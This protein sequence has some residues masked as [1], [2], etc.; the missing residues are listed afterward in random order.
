[1]NASERSAGGNATATTTTPNLESQ[2]GPARTTPSPILK[3]AAKKKSTVA[4]A[5]AKDLPPPRAEK[6]RNLAEGVMS[7]SNRFDWDYMHDGDEVNDGKVHAQK[8]FNL[9]EQHLKDGTEPTTEEMVEVEEAETDEFDMAALLSA[10]SSE[11]NHHLL[12]A[13]DLGQI[14]HLP[15]MEDIGPNHTLRSFQGDMVPADDEQL[16]L[17]QKIAER[18]QTR[19]ESA[20]GVHRYVA[21][22][23]WPGGRVNY[24]FASDTPA[25]VRHMFVAATRQYKRAIPCLSFSNVG[26]LSGSSTDRISRQACK[27]TPAVFVQSHPRKGCYSYV[28]MVR[29][30]KAA[31]LQLQDP[32]CLSVGTAVHELGHALGMA[33]EQSRPDRDTYI[34]ID[35]RNVKKGRERNFGI[36]PSAGTHLKYDYLSVMHYDAYAFAI[37]RSKPTLYALNQLGGHDA[38]QEIGQ[39]MGLST[40]DVDQ[41][42]LAY[43]GE[44]AAGC[45]SNAFTGLG[46]INRPGKSGEDV[47]SS[48]SRCRRDLMKACCACGG[49]YKVQCYEGHPCPKP[50][51]LPPESDHACIVNKANLF[52]E[53]GYS[54][55]IFNRCFYPVEW[56]CPAMSCKHQTPPGVYRVQ[57]CNGK[58]ETDICRLGKC[59]VKGLFAN[60]SIHETRI[61]ED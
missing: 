22:A 60:K 45:S 11:A 48:Q 17:F 37:D 29:Q 5:G 34:R 7:V 54:C 35:L 32:G 55:V 36:T 59:N 18:E 3:G 33:H 58:M 39:R 10:E 31:Q 9:Q 38:T 52:P 12:T 44:L 40:Y 30:L 51:P 26:W 6:L 23:R 4:D 28:G 46:C 41:L 8:V 25:R 50:K 19:D 20:S 16:E 56:Q 42:A 53:A 1:M 14:T 24:C 47:C 15:G 49:G 21:G 61:H 43:R 27:E 2:T 13:H 57:T